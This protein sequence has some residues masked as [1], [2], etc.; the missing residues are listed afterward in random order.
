[1]NIHKALVII[2]MQNDFV[3]GSLANPDAEAIVPRI[4]E[5]ADNFDGVILS[6]QDTHYSS[7]YHMSQEGRKLP[8]MHCEIDSRGWL[9]VDELKDIPY[10]HVFHKSRFG[11]EKLADFIQNSP[12]DE[13]YLCGT[14][15][16]ICVIS[17]AIMIRSIAPETEIKVLSDLCAGTTK[18]NHENAL[19]AM[20]QCQITI[21]KSI[22]EG[23]SNNV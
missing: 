3:T 22:S 21:T 10:T 14:C 4:K 8:I 7:V 13:V 23:G 5:F 2:D 9:I 12:I 19:K 6:T 17:N 16:D 20:A 18:E 1:M 15:T 11:S